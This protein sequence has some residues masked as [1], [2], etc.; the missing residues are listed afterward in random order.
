M[1]IYLILYRRFDN[2]INVKHY[3]T[4]LASFEKVRDPIVHLPFSLT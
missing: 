4:G 2:N 1:I 3:L